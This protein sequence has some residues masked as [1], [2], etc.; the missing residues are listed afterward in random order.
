MDDERLLAAV[1]RFMNRAQ[2]EETYQ[3]VFQAYADSTCESVAITSMQFDGQAGTGQYVLDREA[4]RQWMAILEARLNEMDQVP[5][6]LGSPTM[7]F[8][9]R[10]LGT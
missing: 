1:R 2:V 6:D 8:S 5:T 9:T 7:N 10:I 3:Q 4:M